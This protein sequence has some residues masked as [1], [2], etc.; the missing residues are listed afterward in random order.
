MNYDGHNENN[1]GYKFFQ[2][3]IINDLRQINS[4]KMMTTL[5]PTPV[6]KQY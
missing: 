3:I 1:S 5:A 2:E 4:F 6:A